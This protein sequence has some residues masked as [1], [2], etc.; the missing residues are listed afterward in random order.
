MLRKRKGSRRRIKSMTMEN[1]EE[2]KSA[3]LENDI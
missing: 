1:R 3:G 2:K